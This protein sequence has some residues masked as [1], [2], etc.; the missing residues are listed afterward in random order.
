MQT[1]PR[2]F[3]DDFNILMFSKR[4]ITL[5]DAIFA[6]FGI[7]IQTEK[8]LS[9]LKR[10]Y[11]K[12]DRHYHTINHIISSLSTYD[13]IRNNIPSGHRRLAL[14]FAIFYHDIIYVPQKGDMFNI[15][16][17]IDAAMDALSKF[18]QTEDQIKFVQFVKMY[19]TSTN[20]KYLFE[21]EDIRN[22]M[23]RNSA[24]MS[25]IDLCGFAE[26]WETFKK[27]NDNIRKE[28]DIFSDEDF[29]KG[30]IQFLKSV[31]A[32]EKI[33]LTSEFRALETQARSNIERQIKILS[34]NN[35]Q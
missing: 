28:F 22:K 20:H 15:K 3:F 18:T 27:N 2:D 10:N 24:F 23:D 11:T 34:D 6:T 31:L 21:H 13:E 30:Q 29:N 7:D 16:H 25:D 5:C 19:I 35:K 9:W 32:L 8:E 1:N 26:V 4:F 14:Q 17:S 33:F 12:Y